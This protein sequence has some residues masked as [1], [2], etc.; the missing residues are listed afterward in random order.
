MLIAKLIIV[1]PFFCFQD[2]M[3]LQY[4]LVQVDPSSVNDYLQVIVPYCKRFISR[5]VDQWY[6]FASM[7]V[8]ALK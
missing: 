8:I 7:K 4:P 3:V 5:P 2:D 1:Q 6:Y